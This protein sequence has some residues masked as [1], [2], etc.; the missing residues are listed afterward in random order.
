MSDS[1]DPTADRATSRRP[2][3]PA[4]A[5]RGRRGGGHEREVN[6]AYSCVNTRVK[7]K[8]ERFQE[9]HSLKVPLNKEARDGLQ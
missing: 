1:T 4:A 2:A 6:N 3:A 5:Q 7:V 8:L 9:E